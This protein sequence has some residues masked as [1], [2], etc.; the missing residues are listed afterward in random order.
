MLTYY[1]YK[2]GEFE[3]VKTTTLFYPK[4]AYRLVN[5]LFTMIED[6]HGKNLLDIE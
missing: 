5:G 6:E 1:I 4:G 3:Q 2:N